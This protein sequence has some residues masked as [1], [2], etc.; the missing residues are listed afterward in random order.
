MVPCKQNTSIYFHQVEFVGSEN[1][2]SKLE[3]L[4]AKMDGIARQ[5]TKGLKRDFQDTRARIEGRRVNIKC[6]NTWMQLGH[7]LT[8]NLKRPNKV[9]VYQIDQ[10]MLTLNE[11]MPHNLCA[12]IFELEFDVSISGGQTKKYCIG[13]QVY[14][15]ELNTQS[16]IIEKDHSLKLIKGPGESFSNDLVFSEFVGGIEDGHDNNFD[17][18]MKA[19]I[20][21][22]SAA[23]D[24]KQIQFKRG[25]AIAKA[26]S[27]MP[28]VSTK[29]SSQMP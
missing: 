29:A 3:E 2:E 4:I 7:T 18:G 6:H 20:S 25:Q 24:D 13:Y 28:S 23:P 11:F 5:S 9:G 26:P 8:A 14:L 16:E 10:Q 17:I 22:R 27:T 21:Q 1:F 19:Y 15:P 12:I